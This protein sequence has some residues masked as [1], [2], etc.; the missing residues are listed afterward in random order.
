M[1]AALALNSVVL[2]LPPATG[3]A[4]ATSFAGWRFRMDG[5]NESVLPMHPDADPSASWRVSANRAVLL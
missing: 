4:L 3:V 5:Q 2:L 1:M